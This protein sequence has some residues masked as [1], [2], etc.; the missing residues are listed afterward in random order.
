MRDPAPNWENLALRAGPDGTLL[1]AFKNPALKPLT[2]RTL[3]SV[4]AERHASPEDTAI[5]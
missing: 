5:V 1:L 2:G 4:A 3:A